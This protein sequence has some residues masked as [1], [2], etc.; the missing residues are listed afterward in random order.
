MAF[1]EGKGVQDT[2]QRIESVCSS[3]LSSVQ[4]DNQSNPPLGLLPHLNAELVSIA[5]C[6]FLSANIAAGES[7]FRRKLLILLLFHRIYD[8]AW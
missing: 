5:Y 1:L 3:K 7:S 8:L 6:L 4:F 2:K